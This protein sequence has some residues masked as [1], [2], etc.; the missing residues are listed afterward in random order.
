MVF[1]ASLQHCPGCRTRE[2]AQLDLIGSGT[3]WSLT[4]RCSQCGA[5]RSY[6][7]QTEGHPVNGACPARQLGDERP[8]QIIRVGQ[9][10]GELDRLEPL[11]CTEPTELD[12]V[13]WRASLAAV[14][15]ALT[16][17]YELRKFVP[18]NVQMI[19]D[20]RLDDDERR[21]RAARRERYR[22][23]W[24]NG[25][26]DRLLAARK[27]FGE[28]APR[29]WALEERESPQTPKRG[30]IDRASLM[31]HERWVR[32]GREGAGRLE[33]V[34]FH[35]RGSRLGGVLFQGGYL[36]SVVLDGA[37]LDGA[38]L[39][40]CELRDLSALAAFCTSIDLSRATIVGGTFARSVL[41]LAVFVDAA[42]EGTSFADAD[43]DRSVWRGATVTGASFER[44]TF[45]NSWLDG[46]QF[47]GCSFK[48]A[49]LR[50]LTPGIRATTAGA[51]FEDCDLREA[52][53]GGRDLD[54]ATFVRCKLAGIRGRPSSLASVTIEAP[55][56]STEGDGSALGTAAEVLERW[57][58]A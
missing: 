53:W 37:R 30:A 46:G 40:D 1:A 29:I 32:A 25:E 10:M 33:V 26:L 9:F 57:R 19:P 15:R 45:G 50:L 47:R 36:E 56:L 5:A 22:L 42:I 8:S 20:T 17:L 28:D 12:P 43:L 51:V 41:A 34:G 24:L 27:R 55:D 49:D 21:D 39:M 35:A 14:E 2:P 38:R 13:R 11:V 48:G 18:P 58:H 23:A 7:W 54:G 16:C 52:R 3:S 44:A 4:G 6:G 31:A